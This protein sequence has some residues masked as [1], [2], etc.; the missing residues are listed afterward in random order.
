MVVI[1]FET[2]EHVKVLVTSFVLFWLS[3]MNKQMYEYSH[4]LTFVNE[5]ALKFLGVTSE[6]QTMENGTAPTALW[7][8]H[9]PLSGQ[10]SKV[11]SYAD[12]LQKGE[13]E[14]GHQNRKNSLDITVEETEYVGNDIHPSQ[15]QGNV[16]LN[17]ISRHH[18]CL[19]S[20]PHDT[21]HTQFWGLAGITG[22]N[23]SSWN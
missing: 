14:R 6:Y 19:L 10:G 12:D 9:E 7:S 21:I 13:E 5:A 4:Q 17:A 2:S 23:G 15:M 1:G 16:L 20:R 11:T 3:L 22:A 18:A 8:A